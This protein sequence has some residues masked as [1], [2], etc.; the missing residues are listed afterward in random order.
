ML[1]GRTRPLTFLSGFQLIILCSNRT[2]TGADLT[3]PGIRPVPGPGN[4]ARVL[5]ALVDTRC[6]AR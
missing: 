2:R 1:R 4:V 3:G 6:A 5:D